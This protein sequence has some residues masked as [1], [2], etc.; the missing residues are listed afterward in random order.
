M[1]DCYYK[2]E[3][4]EVPSAG[5]HMD[6]LDM[7]VRAPIELAYGVL[8]EVVDVTGPHQDEIN[9]SLSTIRAALLTWNQID[10]QMMA[11]RARISSSR[12]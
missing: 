3:E 8:E 7:Y 11:D 10:E 4:G 6:A 9:N 1:K 5:D 2:L 12:V